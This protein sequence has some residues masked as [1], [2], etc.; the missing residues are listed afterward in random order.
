MRMIDDD[1]EETARAMRGQKRYVRSV[2]EPPV[3]VSSTS[4]AD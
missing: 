1:N 2:G 4:P 3:D